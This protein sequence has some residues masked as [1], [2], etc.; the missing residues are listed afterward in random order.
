MMNGDISVRADYFFIFLFCLFCFF[1]LHLFS[2]FYFQLQSSGIYGE[3]STFLF[4]ITTSTVSN[5][6]ISPVRFLSTSRLSYT[7]EIFIIDPCKPACEVIS[8]SFLLF[9]LFLLFFFFRIFF[10]HPNKFCRFLKSGYTR[11]DSRQI[12]YYTKIRKMPLM[13]YTQQLPLL[14]VI[15]Y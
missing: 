14:L 8:F 7:T 2:Y 9:L 1:L 3:G 13:K 5:A 12:L 6:P 15:I 11:K 4:T 10:P